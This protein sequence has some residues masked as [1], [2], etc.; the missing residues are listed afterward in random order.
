MDKKEIL[1]SEIKSEIRAELNDIETLIIE[2]EDYEK[3]NSKA[4][5]RAKA[6]ILH[7]FYNACERIFRI[8]SKIVNGGIP[9]DQYWHKRLLYRMTVEI[10]G[11]RPMVISKKLAG[12]L[13][14][15]LSFRHLFRNIYGFELESNRLDNL[16][17]IFSST[18]KQFI[19]EIN[20]FLGKL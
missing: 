18:A 16:V 6:S 9:E 11:V 12:D 7:D 4:F 14:E 8:I 17:K 1:K 3:K 20:E 13:D 15:F 5:R 19:K 2:I 10:E